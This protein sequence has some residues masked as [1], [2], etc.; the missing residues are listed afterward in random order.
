[1][2]RLLERDI[3]P[4]REWQNQ[5]MS[6]IIHQDQPVPVVCELDWLAMIGNGVYYMWNGVDLLVHDWNK[7]EFVEPVGSEYEPP[8]PSS[9]KFKYD[10]RRQ[11]WT[12][13]VR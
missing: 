7:Q 9:I 5:E 11:E 3:D 6:I 2:A 8:T 12:V 10:E 13:Q 1:V 4:C